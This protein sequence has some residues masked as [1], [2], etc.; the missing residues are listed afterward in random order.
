MLSFIL[1]AYDARLWMY[2]RV[3]KMCRIFP[4]SGEMTEAP[5]ENLKDEEEEEEE[6]DACIDARFL[7]LCIDGDV[8]DLVC[9]LEDM[10]RVGEMLTP[11]I[12]NLTD[13]SG[14]VTT[15]LANVKLN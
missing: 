11:E 5:C 6:L 15:T 3:A 9:L 14:K 8:E 4:F 1:K 10:A 7:H 13:S 2:V 12:I